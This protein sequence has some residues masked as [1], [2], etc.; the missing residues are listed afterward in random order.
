MIVANAPVPVRSEDST[1]PTS[2]HSDPAT[3]PSLVPRHGH[4]EA[5]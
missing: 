5:P 4:V 3:K 2:F 1:H